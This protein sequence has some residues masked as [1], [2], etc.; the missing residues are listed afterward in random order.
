MRQTKN[1][2]VA[3]AIAGGIIV[4]TLAALIMAPLFLG[5]RTAGSHL[6]AA[7]FRNDRRLVAYAWYA[8]AL[9]NAHSGGRILSDEAVR[10][11]ITRPGSER[12]RTWGA[13]SA[14]Q[15]FDN[16]SE[17]E[18]FLRRAASDPHYRIAPRLVGRRVR[19]VTETEPFVEVFAID[20]K[21]SYNLLEHTAV[22]VK[23]HLLR[24]RNALSQN[25]MGA[26]QK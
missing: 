9:S 20:R 5:V 2:T 23:L 15:P 18:D 10:E 4:C 25:G 1:R 21:S 24:N 26:G 8:R 13:G 7:N 14:P 22:T 3:V 12:L 16:W 11:A 17:L 19:D 6:V